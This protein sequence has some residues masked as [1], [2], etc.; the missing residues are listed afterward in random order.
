VPE[1]LR[2]TLIDRGLLRSLVLYFERDHEGRFC[3]PE[4]YPPDALLTANTHDLA[5]LW[6]K[7]EGRDLRRRH[8][9]GLFDDARLHEAEQER[10]GTRHR[11][12]EALWS[13]GCLPHGH[14]P[15]DAEELLRA[16]CEFMAKTR[17]L[18]LGVSLDDITGEREAINIPGT[19]AGQ[20]NN[21]TRRLSRSLESLQRDASLMGWLR[22]WTGRVRGS[23]EP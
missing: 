13:S 6:G 14:W 1:G 10:D 8:E 9:L 18:L 15:R 4:H 19:T 21:W 20:A 5:T 7:W 16:V 23:D 2:E 11:L 12:M 17:C 22:D 3:G